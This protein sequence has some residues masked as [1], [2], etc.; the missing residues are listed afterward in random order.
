LHCYTKAINH[1]ILYFR[2]MKTNINFFKGKTTN[3]LV[4]LFRY[5]WVGGISFIIDYISLFIFTE[6][7]HINYLISAAIAFILGLTTNYQL[8][9]IWVFNNSRLNNKF[10][11]FTIFSIIGIIGLGLNEIIIY[12]CSE[13]LN[14]YY[15][16]SKLIS[17]AVVFFW[18]FM[19]R[20]Y[21]LFT[22]YNSRQN[23]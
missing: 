5:L 16:I 1:Q 13:Y 11:E 21:I 7:L 4:Q 15:M 10:T 17:T 18:N 9:T 8:S 20:K 2:R 12:I 6:Y 22:N 19:G 3:T 14:L 23:K